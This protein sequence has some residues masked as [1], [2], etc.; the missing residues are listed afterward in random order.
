VGVGEF[1]FGGE[2]GVERAE[3]QVEEVRV[4]VGAAAVAHDR[5]RFVKGERTAVDAVGGEGVEDV[6]DRGDATLERY[7]LA[8]QAA[9][10]AGAVDLLICVQASIA[11][12]RASSELEPC[13]I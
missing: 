11:P 1:V 10:V 2:H 9:G 5:D 8:A 6:G 7:L 12:T 13:R 3:E 4:E